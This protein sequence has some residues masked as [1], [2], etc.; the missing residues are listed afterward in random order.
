MARA[1]VTGASGFIG[2]HLCEEL[3]RRHWDVIALVR[4]SSDLSWLREL[5]IT[6]SYGDVVDPASLV[7][8]VSLADCIFHAAGT[9]RARNQAE[10]DRINCDGTRNLAL[11]AARHA[12]RVRRFIFFSSLAAA[13]PTGERCGP[14]SQYGRS[15]FAAEQALKEQSGRI[16]TTVLRLPAT[17]G[18]RDR[19]GLSMFQ[20]FSGPVLPVTNMKFSLCYVGDVVDA[21]IRLAECADCSFGPF[22]VCDGNV[23]T[24]GKLGELAEQLLEHKARQV[25]VPAW[26]FKTL[27]WSSEMLSSE[28]PFFNRDKAREMTCRAWTCDY[29]ELQARTGFVPRCDVMTG[30]K[31]TIAWYR[32]RKWLRAAKGRRW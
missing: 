11:A 4:K 28:I 9:S 15:K 19:E 17:F 16:S 3:I 23:Y 18:P 31:L 27:A 32:E 1:L 7:E 8:P 29:E 26:L 25:H 10:F 6:L 14:V 13:G 5:P 22:A 24:Y 30:L 20:A 12:G 2:S 21:A